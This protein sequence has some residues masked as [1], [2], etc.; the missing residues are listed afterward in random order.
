MSGIIGRIGRIGR[1]ASRICAAAGAVGVVA[2]A[3]A[4]GG[5]AFAQS[6]NINEMGLFGEP[7]PST[8]A[9]SQPAQASSTP[10]AEPQFSAGADTA[11]QFQQV[12]R[13][14][15]RAVVVVVSV[16]PNQQGG[17]TPR[18]F[19]TAWFFEPSRLGTNSH[20]AEPVS[21]MLANGISVFVVPN[22]SRGESYKVTRAIVHPRYDEKTPNVQ[23]RSPTGIPY[24]VGIL[25][26]EGAHDTVVNLAGMDTL[27]RLDAGTPLAY[28]GFPL[29]L[30]Q[31]SNINLNNPIATMQTGIVTS[32]SDF[33]LED[34]GPSRNLL[35]RHS[36]PVT[37]GS[38]GSP[39]FLSNG[40]VVGAINA[41]NLLPGQITLSDGRVIRYRVPS[42][43][44]INF[45]QRIDILGDLMGR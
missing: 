45:A 22:K 43:A 2:F 9:P 36:L 30:L 17:F 13:D 19:G 24:D 3:L 44:L 11:T 42:A 25:E 34:A 40:D 28:I 21:R 41:M 6:V 7:E 15:E 12:A 10:A 8:A 23:G 39:V 18:P 4:Q 5:S 29:E 16:V 14:Y 1:G 37:G 33:Y 38:S 32:M 27:Q 26:V 31:G 20:I 35:I